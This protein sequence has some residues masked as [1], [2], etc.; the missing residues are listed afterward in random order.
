MLQRGWVRKIFLSLILSTAILAIANLETI[1][2]DYRHA[3]ERLD[4]ASSGIKTRGPLRAHLH[5]GNLIPRATVDS[6]TLSFKNSLEQD[7]LKDENPYLHLASLEPLQEILRKGIGHFQR[8][9]YRSSDYQQESGYDVVSYIIQQKDG[10]VSTVLAFLEQPQKMVV[11]DVGAPDDRIPFVLF[12]VGHGAMGSY[13]SF[14]NGEQAE[15]S[16]LTMVEA[17]ALISRRISSG[18]P[19][20]SVSR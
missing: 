4:Q 16:E 6:P 19:F 2:Q 5:L 7:E 17:E 15:S 14:C 8:E 1:W 13:T 18:V 9:T 11:Q 3:H 12:V 10:T 20:F